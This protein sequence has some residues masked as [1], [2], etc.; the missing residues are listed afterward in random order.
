V[1]A[2]AP[3]FA[4]Q[5]SISGIDFGDEPGKLY[6]PLKSVVQ[7][8]GLP[9]IGQGASLTLCGK[10]VNSPRYLF[11]GTELVAV[12]NLQQLGAKVAWSEYTEDAMISFAGKTI[13]VHRGVKRAE[14]NKSRQELRAYQGDLLVL[15]T[16][17]ST[18]RKGHGTPSG[19][20]EAHRKERMHYSHI[21]EDSPM[22]WA[23]Q[24][25]GN[26]FV[27]GFTSVPKRPAS[28][29]CIRVPLKGKNAARFFWHWVSIGTPVVVD[30]MWSAQND[31]MSAK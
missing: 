15:D 23:V 2:A 18:G 21:Y 19:D 29:G 8:L 16:H 12:A 4:Q 31:H 11:D 22:P 17:V 30:N 10:P 6:V 14:V 25:H 24:I 3:C 28:H 7:G 20:F 5:G 27:H 9:Q 1:L 13:T 26:I